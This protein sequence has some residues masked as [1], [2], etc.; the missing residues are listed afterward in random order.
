[1]SLL[2]K[3]LI[4]FFKNNNVTLILSI[5]T[6]KEDKFI[7]FTKTN[8]ETFNNFITNINLAQEVFKDTK[9]V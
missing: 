8:K 9:I 7:K 4:E 3:D 5:D 2:N 1:M 6:L